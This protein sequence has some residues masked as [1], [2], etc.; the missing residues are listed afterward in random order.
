MT[1]CRFILEKFT[2]TVPGYIIRGYNS[3]FLR[4]FLV[5]QCLSKVLYLPLV[6][7]KKKLK[8]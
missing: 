5:L 6:S 3:I 4:R 7:E 8:T 2:R 1:V